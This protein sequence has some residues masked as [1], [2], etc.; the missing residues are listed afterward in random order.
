MKSLWKHVIPIS[1]TNLVFKYQYCFGWLRHG[2]DSPRR[3]II[4]WATGFHGPPWRGHE[5]PRRGR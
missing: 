4:F 5:V 1:S 3:D 2:G